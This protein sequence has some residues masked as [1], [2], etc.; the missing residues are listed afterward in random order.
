MRLKCLSCEAVTRMVYACAAT[1]PHLV[2]V[3]L[4]RLGLHNEPSNLRVRLQAQIDAQ[5]G[6]QYDA[7]L[8]AYGLCGQATAGLVAGEIP[9][10]IPRA[11]DCI[12]LFLGSRARYQEQF[13]HHPGTYWYALDYLQRR[14]HTGTA[15]SLGSGFDGDRLQEL[16][17]EYVEKYGEDNAQYLMETMGAWQSHYN[18]AA[19]IDVGVG[20]GAAVEEEARREA[21]RRG[22]RFERLTG[23]LSLI[24]R[25]LYG[26]WDEDFLVLSP[27][28]QIRMAYDEGV[29]CAQRPRQQLDQQRHFT[30]CLLPGGKCMGDDLCD[31]SEQNIQRG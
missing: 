3:E 15:L 20:H 4:F 18:R 19:Y 17:Q 9:L 25:L 6:Q 7:L 24:R 5:Q 10:V 29:V 1:S 8:L 31:P 13:E 27:G 14:D 26:E 28:E 16:Y 21:G 30:H 22:W 12:T 2:D 23:N 11:H